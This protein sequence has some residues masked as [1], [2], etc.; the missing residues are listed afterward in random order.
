MK[1]SDILFCNKSKDTGE[2]VGFWHPTM[3]HGG[4]SDTIIFFCQN[5]QVCISSTPREI[6]LID[7]LMKV[8]VG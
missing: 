3:T 2:G 1:I 4:D 8:D 5:L 7:A 6:T